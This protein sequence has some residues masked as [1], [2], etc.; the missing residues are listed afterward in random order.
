MQYCLLEYKEKILCISRNSFSTWL[1]FL[2]TM[3][4]L[5]VLEQEQE[6]TPNMVEE[7]FHPV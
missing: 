1:N 2:I 4:S 3:S 7:I 6:W 5:N